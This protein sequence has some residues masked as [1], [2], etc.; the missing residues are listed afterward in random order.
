MEDDMYDPDKQCEF[1]EFIAIFIIATS[2]ILWTG[3]IVIVGAY[4]VGI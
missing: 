3:V 1:D 4:V 2:V